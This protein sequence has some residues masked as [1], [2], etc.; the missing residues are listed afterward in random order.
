MALSHT[1]YVYEKIKKGKLSMNISVSSK[2]KKSLEN[3]GYSIVPYCSD[4]Q[5]FTVIIVF[6]ITILLSK[7]DRTI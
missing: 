3:S 4:H 7:Q 5:F 1:H 6:P 2:E